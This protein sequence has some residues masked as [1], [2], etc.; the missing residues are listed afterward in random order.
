MRRYPMSFSSRKESDFRKAWVLRMLGPLANHTIRSRTMRDKYQKNGSRRW[1]PE[2]IENYS[3]SLGGYTP[4]SATTLEHGSPMEVVDSPAT[5]ALTSSTVFSPF[6]RD[7]SMKKQFISPTTATS[8]DSLPSEGYSDGN[9]SMEQFFNFDEATSMSRESLIS[10]PSDEVHDSQR[11]NDFTIH[12]SSSALCRQSMMMLGGPIPED[13]SLPITQN[14][15][16]FLH[17][18]GISDLESDLALEFS[19]LK[20]QTLQ[21]KLCE[22]MYQMEQLDR[23]HRELGQVRDALTKELHKRTS[24]T[25]SFDSGYFSSGGMSQRTS[26][27]KRRLSFEDGH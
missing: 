18:R 26:G 23:D 20:I 19:H 3:G 14:A 24:S 5:A 11:R 8:D 2:T 22:T 15:Q 7:H 21:T 10:L 16:T 4:Q 9:T 12:R 17:H 27:A 6:L 25:P 1:S 13:A